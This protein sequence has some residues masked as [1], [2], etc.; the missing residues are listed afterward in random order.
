[1]NNAAK[2]ANQTVTDLRETSAGIK[3]DMANSNA[4]IGMLLQDTLLADAF[5]AT[6]YNLET[7][8]E[9]LDTNMMAVRNNFLFRGYF[10]KQAKRERK[11]QQE[12]EKA[13]RQ[14]QK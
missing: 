11:A 3:A 14:A 10:R 13:A 8:T 1:M 9:K 4:P 7:S 12:K 6:I 2:N 5:K